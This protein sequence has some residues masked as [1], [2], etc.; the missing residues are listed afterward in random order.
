MRDMMH[1]DN[2]DSEQQKRKQNKN[3]TDINRIG[4]VCCSCRSL[5]LALRGKEVQ[6][7]DLA[8][9]SKKKNLDGQNLKK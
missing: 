6:I 5:D 2:N 3:K 8:G 1:A 4:L 9:E 7:H